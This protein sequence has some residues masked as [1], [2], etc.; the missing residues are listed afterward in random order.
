MTQPLQIDFAAFL[1]ERLIDGATTVG[2]ILDSATAVDQAVNEHLLIAVLA[3]LRRMR[4]ISFREAA[5]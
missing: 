1:L 3:Q 2:V 4:V 5:D